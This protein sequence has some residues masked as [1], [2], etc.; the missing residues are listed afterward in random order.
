MADGNS[1]SKFPQPYLQS[2]REDDP[3]LIRVDQD[4][5]EIGSRKSG[6]PSALDTERMGIE[7]VGGKA[8]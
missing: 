8:S 7:H 5:G 4:R 6:M 1:T 2:I 3:I